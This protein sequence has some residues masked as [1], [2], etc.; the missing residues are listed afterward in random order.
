[1][2]GHA[3]FFQHFSGGKKFANCELAEMSR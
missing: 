1:V 3:T 2:V